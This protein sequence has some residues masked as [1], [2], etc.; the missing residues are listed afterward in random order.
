MDIKLKIPTSLF[1][2]IEVF[3]IKKMNEEVDD[4]QTTSFPNDLI[5]KKDSCVSFIYNS[6]PSK[7]DMNIYDEKHVRN[8]FDDDDELMM[9]SYSLGFKL[10]VVRQK[11]E[12][13][14]AYY[15]MYTER[16]R[17]Y[18]VLNQDTTCGISAILH[19]QYLVLPSSEL[20]NYS[21]QY[22]YLSPNRLAKKRLIRN[23]ESDFELVYVAQSCLSWEALQHQYR[24]IKTL[25]A[26]SSQS[27]RFEGN[28]A[29]EFQ[30]FRVF[31]TRFLEDEGSE[32]KRVSNYV[33]RRFSA[34]SLIQVPALSGFYEEE[35]EYMMGE[36]STV[37]EVL[38]AIENCIETFWEFIKSEN[39]KSWW[40]PRA[41]STVEDPRDLEILIDLS[42][43]LRKKEILMKDLQ[44]KARCWLR[45][46]VINPTEES[47]RKDT[48]LAMV[49]LKLVSRVLHMSTLSS[50]QLKWCQQKL[51]NIEFQQG[52]LFRTCTTTFFPA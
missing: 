25:Q 43:T 21:P 11:E 5:S 40:K 49:D 30:K 7:E 29:G 32:G 18:D 3:D 37:D 19:N 51:Q 17:V 38:G 23:L 6:N 22:Y 4:Q 45:R 14:D 36:G 31:L 20:V 50:S 27:G 16:M 52:K 42:L 2:K 46:V 1:S 48:L 9:N 47:E 8:W 39:H 44:G 33:R 24:K 10:P 12:V 15:K 28:V 13:M 26:S 41:L 34:K 35:N